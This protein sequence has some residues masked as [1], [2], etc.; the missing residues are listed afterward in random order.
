[1]HIMENDSLSKIKEGYNQVFENKFTINIGLK[2]IIKMKNNGTITDRDL[3][4][5]KLIFLFKFATLDQIYEYLEL[6]SEEDDHVAAKINI[7]NRIEKLVKYRVFNKFMLTEDPVIET[8]QPEALQI[9]C[10]DLGGRHLLSHYST[11]D[12]TDW[13]TIENM[14]SSAIISKDLQVLNFY[15][16]LLRTCPDRVPYYQP[17]QDMRLGKKNFTPNFEFAIEN[18][19][20]NS[21]FVGEVVTDADFPMTYRERLF[22]LE[23]LFTTNNWKKYYYDSSVPPVLLIVAENDQLAQE[24]GEMMNEISELERY[25]ITTYERINKKLYD[26]GAFLKF[27][28]MDKS[29]KEIRA[30]SFLP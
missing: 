1:M 13:Y 16:S 25:R 7:K 14:K 27:E 15:L 21:Y 5:T 20:V 19:G 12:V 29:L 24:L 26:L 8:V 17:G 18:S 28:E 22:K 10:L 6:T 4:M 11:E 30:S 3:K 9:Y 2:E 23:D